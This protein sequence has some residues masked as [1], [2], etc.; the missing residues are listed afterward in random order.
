MI[1]F[2]N[3]IRYD[4]IDRNKTGKYLKYA[5][6]EIVLVVI[7]IL[8]A[9][10]INNLNEERKERKREIN[11]L[12]NL[13]TDLANALENNRHFSIYRFKTAKNSSSL[14]HSQSPQNIQDVK[15]YTDMYEQVFTWIAFVPN[16]NTFKE[17]LSSGN[18]SL[19]K[20]DTIKN[21]LLELDEMYT[22]ISQSEH[23]MRR[24]YE[25]YLYDI[26]I[27]NV[28]ALEFFD[29]TNPK[30]GLLNRLKT[31]DIAKSKYD[32]LISDSQWQYNSQTFNNGLK[33]AML[34]NGLL[35]SLHKST[36]LHIEELIQFIDEE[37][38]K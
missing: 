12:Y 33:L 7:G 23:H 24:E 9:L 16:N 3:K 21:S 31:K 19:I 35:A 15:T 11:Y 8:I 17:L 5:A 30:Y 25:Q 13:N 28:S 10:Q 29:T 26:N 14:L 34:N 37:I 27:T 22:Q 38:Q 2:F 20:N 1:K 18:L 32:K 6:G 4:L 36:S